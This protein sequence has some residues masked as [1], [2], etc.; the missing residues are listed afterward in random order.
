MIRPWAYLDPEDRDTFRATI[1]FLHKRLA[2][3]GT[4]DWALRLKPGQR[5]ER[6]AIEDL[7][8]SPGARDLQEPWATAWRLIEESWSSGFSERDDGTA[9]YGI[10]KRL[11]AGDRSGTAITA[12]VNL[13]AP[14][15]KVEPIGSWRWQFSKKPRS[16]S[17]FEHLLSA[18]LTSG[19]LIDLNVLDLANLTDTEFLTALASALEAAIS[20]GLDIAR[21][22]GWDGQ[23]RLWQLGDLGRVYYVSSGPRAHESKDPD[24]HNLGIAPSVKLLYAVVARIVDLDLSAAKLQVSRWRLVDSPVHIRLWAA[25]SRNPQVTPAGQVNSFLLELDDRRF[26]D[27]HVFPEI[28]ELRALRFNNLDRELQSVI[29]KRIQKG[30]PRNHWPK[31]ADAEKVKKARLYWSV[32]ELKRIELAGGQLP[33]KSKSWLDAR[34]SRFRD[35]VTIEI[36]EGFPEGASADWISP[37]PDKRYDALE[38]SSRLR[39]LETALATNRGGWDDDPAERADDWLQQ[40][41]KAALV[42]GDFEAAGNGGDDFPRVWN[43]FSWAHSP[44]PPEPA[45][46]ALRDLQGEAARVL[47]LLNQLS[48]GTLSAAI[49]GISAW[50]GAWEKQIV[51]TPQGLPVWLRVWPI[52]VEATNLRPEKGDDA[53]LSV[54]A[55]SVDDDREPMDLDTL[56]TP[57]GK[58]VGVFLAACPTLTPGSQAFAVGS[59]ERLMRDVVIASTGRSGLIARHRMIEELPYFLRATPDWTQEYLIA[60]LLKDDGAS[61]A[62][63]RAIARRTHFTDVLEIIGGAMAE[64]ATDRR[65][66]RETRRRLVFSIVI[67]SLHAFREGRDSVVP[68]PRIQ[69][70]LRTLDDEVRASAA[71]AIQQFVR[72]LSEKVPE[73]GQ[74]ESEEP[75]NAA[76]A[77][78]L[79]RSAAAPFLRDVWPQERSLATAGV[80]G[81]LADLPATSV[82]AFAEA[83]DTI[84]RFLIPF[85]CW[86]MLDYGL[87]GENEGEKKLALIDDEAKAKALLRLLDLTVGTSAEAVIP[88]DLT[89]ALDQ[90]REVAPALAD[91]P[92]FRRLSTSARR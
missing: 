88:H 6:I 38:G 32:R 36:D 71:N 8:N 79:F 76:S 72:E 24:V 81:A 61:L 26:W 9:I 51:S 66:G 82:E 1:A 53:D 86:S 62:L 40:P 80:S 4:I 49:E 68:N 45:G 22:L 23:G 39:A 73:E 48:E 84:A 83:V 63:W 50:L 17:S 30:P 14:R 64:R 2:E 43:R 20:R 18:S 33:K 44:R 46:A 78:A 25:M 10:Q 12:I 13:V 70:M 55:R 54:T 67:E 27:L 89:D 60:P 37:S 59:V 7:L 69:Q 35:L 5:V 90:I 16:P 31:K 21:R 65:L 58:L 57:A 41:E 28:A 77:A 15:L 34:I 74:P 85:D 29:S 87:Y 19:D 52:A 92:A 91:A 3:Q 56:N 47:A 75:E 11:R 42:L